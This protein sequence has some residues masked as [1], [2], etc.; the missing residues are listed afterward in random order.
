[1][2]KII[3]KNDMSTWHMKFR[4]I[5]VFRVPDYDTQNKFGVFKLLSK[6]PE[7]DS[8]FGFR[9][10]VFLPSPRASYMYFLWAKNTLFWLLMFQNIMRFFLL[11]LWTIDNG[12]WPQILIL[13]FYKTNLVMKFNKSKKAIKCLDFPPT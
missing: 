2:R 11:N 6:I 3:I 7:R 12:F 13:D 5:Q 8:S 9:V 1:M 4:V 10:M